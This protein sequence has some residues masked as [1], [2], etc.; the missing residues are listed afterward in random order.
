[1]NPRG[2]GKFTRLMVASATLAA[3]A[4]VTIFGSAGP[5]AAI[6][7]LCSVNEDFDNPG[8]VAVRCTGGTGSYRAMAYCTTKAG[9]SGIY[10][11]GEWV[12]VGNGWSVVQCSS[13]YPYLVDGGH[14]FK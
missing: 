14:S 5:A 8:T 6:P 4:A 3:T 10:R 7:S 9:G 12:S 11:F 2:A 1:M 13:S